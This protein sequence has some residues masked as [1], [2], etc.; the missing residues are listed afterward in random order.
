MKITIETISRT[1]TGSGEPTGVIDS[2]AVFDDHGLP[3]IPAKRL[4]GLL[5][6][7]ALEVVEMLGLKNG[8]ELVKS[9][10][11]RP[12]LAGGLQGRS[13]FADLLVKGHDPISAWLE[14]QRQLSS[15]RGWLF[16]RERLI[17]A[18]S[19]LSQQ[20]AIDRDGV[21]RDHSLRTS[22]VIRPR[23]CFEGAVGGRPLDG[24]E[25][26]LLY[27]A[28]LNLRR[29]GVHRNRGW[30]LVKCCLEG[31]GF[32]AVDPAL[33]SLL[34]HELVPSREET[35]GA[36]AV[37]SCRAFKTGS[38]PSSTDS[39]LPFT[40]TL[41][42]PVLVTQPRGE[43]NTVATREYLPGSLIRG[44][45]A[46]RLIRARGLGCDA[47]LDSDFRDFFLNG[48]VLFGPAWPAAG[49]REFQPAPLS[50]HAEKGA[51]LETGSDT[52]IHDLFNGEPAV[53]TKALGGFVCESSSKV[54][55]I[56]VRRRFFFHNA[57]S[58]DRALGH[59]EEGG[60]FYYESLDGGQEF[61]GC[62]RGPRDILCSLKEAVSQ[63][64]VFEDSVGRS[65]TAQYGRVSFRFGDPGGGQQGSAPG[66]V[67]PGGESE[68]SGPGEGT[69]VGEF[70]LVA[71]SPLIFYDPGTGFPVVSE[72]LLQASLEKRLGVGLVVENSFAATAPVES[73]V[74]AWKCRTPR[75]QA[76]REG[77]V[78]RFRVN[79]GKTV[80]SVLLRKLE[81]EGLGEKRALGFGRVRLIPDTGEKLSGRSYKPAI[82]DTPP[83]FPGEMEPLLREILSGALIRRLEADAAGDA[84]EHHD[85]RK[86]DTLPNHLIGRLEALLLSAAGH[87]A[88]RAA[89]DEFREKPA[90]RK[91]QSH[92]L[93]DRLHD[94]DEVKGKVAGMVGQWLEAEQCLWFNKKIYP[95]MGFSF[96][97]AYWLAFFRALRRYNK[98]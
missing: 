22:R 56:S 1:L 2:D 89:L 97:R 68:E 42:S 19:A 82:P 84:K 98:G 94:P 14:H 58:E 46:G 75:E 39:R 73:F 17:A 47:H 66:T 29:M 91:I 70:Q 77:S 79:G 57:R 33:E 3:F 96:F 26:A 81:E 52:E 32:Q 87:C 5:R 36:S 72:S 40:V 4:K 92:G 53:K 35:A 78:F 41:L 55:K 62:L 9:V 90:G 76:F 93:R 18:H 51:V 59:S 64:G 67:H 13:E 80:P 31:A 8:M 25:K 30:G 43:Q 20:T 74:G 71:L 65:R 83:P 86:N 61:A 10:F 63:G 21:V 15:S 95:D 69:R 34:N 16:S 50:L 23:L 37:D 27:L 28:A 54:E 45:L 12:G 48:K 11:G 49:G 88:L 6:E 44:L 60:I 85:A 24:P 7:S 38:G